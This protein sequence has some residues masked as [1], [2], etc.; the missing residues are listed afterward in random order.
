VIG[1][2]GLAMME[3]LSTEARASEDAERAPRDYS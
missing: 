2:L 3:R 1:E